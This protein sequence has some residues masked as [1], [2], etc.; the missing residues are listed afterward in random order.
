MAR[1]ML[2]SVD[3]QPFGG[4]AEKS[5]KDAITLDDVCKSYQSSEHVLMT[6]MER[7][8]MMAVD[9][10]CFPLLAKRSMQDAGLDIATLQSPSSPHET[11]RRFPSGEEA[12]IAGAIGV[13]RNVMVESTVDDE[14]GELIPGERR[15][16][17]RRATGSHVTGRSHISKHSSGILPGQTAK[18]VVQ[19]T[20][21]R[22]RRIVV[23]SR[24]SAL[25]C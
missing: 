17:P 24:S 12:A 14:L 18:D 1:S 2:E 7:W 5:G 21:P 6:P 10:E 4:D 11:A 19:K 23:N 16:H 13:R 9:D 15:I 3:L 22:N 20:A 8:T 25:R